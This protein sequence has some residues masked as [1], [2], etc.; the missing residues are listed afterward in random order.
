MWI[1]GDGNFLARRESGDIGSSAG[2]GRPCSRPTW[3]PARC[4]R[5]GEGADRSRSGGACRRWRGW[6]LRG[7]RLRF[8]LRVVLGLGTLCRAGCLRSTGLGSW[9][10]IASSLGGIFRNILEMLEQALSGRGCLWAQSCWG[11]HRRSID[12]GHDQNP[13]RKT[14]SMAIILMTGVSVRTKKQSCKPGCG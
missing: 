10:N 4:G 8:Q 7:S 12:S 11:P 3:F 6:C 9:R 2:Q 14:L 13:Y 1:A 5:C